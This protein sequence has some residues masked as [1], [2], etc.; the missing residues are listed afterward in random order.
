MVLAVIA[1]LSGSHCN[2]QSKT[3][4][5]YCRPFLSDLY[6]LQCDPLLLSGLWEYSCG[7]GVA[8]WKYFVGTAKQCSFLLSVG[9]IG[10]IVFAED[11]ASIWKAGASCAE[12]ELV[13]CGIRMY[14]YG[15]L[16]DSEF[17]SLDAAVAGWLIF[18]IFKQKK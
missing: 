18:N 11:F 2:W 8:A 12:R 17:Y 3:G 14:L 9:D 7:A 15:V 5:L 6:V 13:S 10:A 1:G 4:V 16:F